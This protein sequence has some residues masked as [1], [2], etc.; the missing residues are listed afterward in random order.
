MTINLD[1]SRQAT[2]SLAAQAI[3]DTADRLVIDHVGRV[4]RT[5]AKETV[6][7]ADISVDL[8]SGGF[9]AIVGPSGCG[10]STLLRMLAGL[11]TP[12]TGS[13]TFGGR[14]PGQLC[15]E[16]R[17]GVAFQEAGLM[18]WRTVTANIELAFQV[19]RRRAPKARLAELIDLVGLNGFEHARPHELSGGMRQRVALA[20]ALALEPD[21]L[22]L[23]EPFGALDALTR[24]TLNVALLEISERLATTTV[25]ITHSVSEAVFLATKVLVL[26][27]RPGRV[28]AVI[29]VPFG[30]TRTPDLMVD[31]AFH[32]LCDRITTMLTGGRH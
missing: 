16:H 3:P 25:L 9:L 18:P 6:A 21:L 2:G 5:R 14:E 23:D 10:K 27:A 30:Q 26:S 8:D 19:A 24:R 12:D 29:D 4:Y 31:P 32:A 22:L 28:Q 15:R 11:D 7:L 20:R 13:M 17:V 1:E